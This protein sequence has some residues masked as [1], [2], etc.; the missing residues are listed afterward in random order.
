MKLKIVKKLDYSSKSGEVT[1][2]NYRN[3]LHHVPVIDNLKRECILFYILTILSMI[4]L[5][6]K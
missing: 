6:L 5:R 2:F 1:M 4:S 3:S